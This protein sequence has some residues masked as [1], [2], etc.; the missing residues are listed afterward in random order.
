VRNSCEFVSPLSI[1]ALVIS[2][3]AARNE[4]RIKKTPQ[5]MLNRAMPNEVFE[6]PRM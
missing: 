5:K 1:G 4:E 2:A 6:F 3:V